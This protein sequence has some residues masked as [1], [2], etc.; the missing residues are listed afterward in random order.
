[1][2]KGVHFELVA[3]DFRNSFSDG[4]FEIDLMHIDCDW[5]DSVAFCLDKARQYLS[6]GGVIV[7]DDY[8]DYQGCHLAVNNFLARYPDEFVLSTETPHAIL[9]RR[10]RAPATASS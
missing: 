7:V 5:H 6:L 1:L 3:G 9:K 8:N 2:R 10:L 4:N